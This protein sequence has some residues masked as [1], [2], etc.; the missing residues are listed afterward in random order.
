MG[1]PVILKVGD[2]LVQSTSVSYDDLVILYKQYIEQYG[3]VPIFSKCDSRHN[4]PQGRIINR[5][6]ADKGIT[7]NDFLLQFGKVSHVRTES[8]DYDIYVKKYK[9]KSD[10]IGRYILSNELINNHYGL[11]NANWFVKYCPDDDVKTFTDFVKWCGYDPHYALDKEYVSNKLIEL[12]QKLNRPITKQDI[13][14]D[15]V[16]FSEIV[17]VRI[18]GSINK[19][20]KDLGLMK[21]ISTKPISI[22]ECKVRLQTRLENIYKKTGRKFVSW[23]DIESDEYPDKPLNHKT[24][25]YAFRRNNENLNAYMK[26]LGFT[27]CQNNIGNTHTFDDG[28]IVKSTFEFDFS[29]YLRK[30]N[31]EYKRNVK[32]KIFTDEQS[33]IDCDYVIQVNGKPLYIEIAGIIYNTLEDDWRNRKYASKRENSYRDKMILKEKLLLNADADFIF[34]F[35]WDMVSGKY[36]DILS[37]KINEMLEKVA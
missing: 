29:T 24:Y 1:Q 2:R 27:M 35:P 21:S 15:S 28:E 10:A 34:L 36:V 32:Y 19:M 25:H 37:T 30:H 7:Y 4:M 6:I 23:G 3:E 17:V 11:P 13:T 31:I 9:E 16:G 12:E 18:W 20:K 8:K 14:L 5:V 22:E 26:S 33:K